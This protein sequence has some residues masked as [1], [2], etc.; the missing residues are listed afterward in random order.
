MEPNIA[1]NIVKI[2]TSNIHY[3]E[4]GL[5][6]SPSILLLHGASF[7][8]QTWKEIGTLKRLRSQNYRVVAIDLPGYG[9]SEPIANYQSEFLAKF[10][11]KLELNRIVLISPSMSGTY[12]LPFMI[13]HPESLQGLV[14]L[15]PVGIPKLM[16]QLK[17]IELPVLAMWGS[18]DRI[19]PVEQA[20]L[21]VEVMPNAEKIL[22]PK[23]GHACYLKATNKFHD[24]LLQFIEKV[25][26]D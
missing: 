19:V 22:L 5:E 1:S 17:G 13:D 3:L 23:A 20:D 21:L 2:Q 12:S 11:N 14:A 4:S 6:S 15:A 26:K 18:D 9:K 24:H 10:I 25:L 7:S 8:A 16:T